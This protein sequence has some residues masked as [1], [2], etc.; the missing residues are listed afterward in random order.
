MDDHLKNKFR[1]HFILTFLYL[2]FLTHAPLFK[3][4]SWPKVWT[5]KKFRIRVTVTSTK[6]SSV[7]IQLGWTPISPPLSPGSSYPHT[8]IDVTVTSGTATC[9][10]CRHE[11][12]LKGHNRHSVLKRAFTF[13]GIRSSQNLSKA[14]CFATQESNSEGKDHIFVS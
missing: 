9:K 13:A 1:Y 11:G 12:F 14:V 7:Q 2:I 5:K 8:P 6:L 4:Y 3:I 10:S